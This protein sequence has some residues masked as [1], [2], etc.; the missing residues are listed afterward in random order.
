MTGYNVGADGIPIP[1]KVP[2]SAWDVAPDDF[3]EF[4]F[5]KDVRK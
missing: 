2:L 4:Y 3:E 5:W 1:Y